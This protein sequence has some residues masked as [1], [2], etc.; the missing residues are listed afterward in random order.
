[1]FSL[2]KA[3][4]L[5]ISCAIFGALSCTSQK[6]PETMTGNSSAK[7]YLALG[8]S[9]T[10]GE[11]V[12]YTERFP[13]QLVT[14]LG[15][16]NIKVNQPEFV[17]VTGWTTANL[18][19]ALSIKQ[20]SPKY[21]L[22]TLLIGVNNQYQRRNIDEYR[23]EFTTLLNNAIT[24]A[25]GNT[26]KVIVVSIPDYSKTPFAAGTDTA[27][28]ANQIDIFNAA[29]K[30]I[31]LQKQVKYVDIT[32]ISRGSEGSS[33]LVAQDGLHPSGM[34]YGLWVNKILPLAENILQ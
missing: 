14:E 22:V 1:M 27:Y 30:E 12:N 23:Q 2:S 24:Y 11:A 19:A 31:T 16:K 26:S 25:G 4:T 7:N 3:Y 29:N 32:P 5:F 18:L 13:V 9:Y 8:D 6:Q 34:Q 15:K 10:I 28:I 20:P 21:D 33:G 17:A